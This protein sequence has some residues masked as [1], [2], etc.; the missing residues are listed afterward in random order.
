MVER[1]LAP[2][3]KILLNNDTGLLLWQLRM[4]SN[5]KP[6]LVVKQ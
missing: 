1:K 5:L 4:E 6:Y 3:F 2:V